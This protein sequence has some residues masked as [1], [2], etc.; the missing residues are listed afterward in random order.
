[1]S[2]A[3]EILNNLTGDEIAVHS[4]DPKTK[5]HI[6][7]NADRTIS[8]PAKLR[9]VAVEHDRDIETYTFDCPRYLDGNDLFDMHIFINYM[10]PDG[11]PGSYIAQNVVVDAA[12][13]TIIHFEWTIS[14]HVAA[15]K[16][17]LRFLVCA[18][19]VDADG[20]EDKH[21][22]S[23]LCKK[24]SISEGLEC[25]E[26]I[27]NEYPDIITQLLT[28]MDEY[29]TTGGGAAE[30]PKVTIKDDG[31]VLM[32]SDGKWAA[33]ELPRYDG[34]YSIIPSAEND[35]TLETAQKML[36]ADIKVSK[37]PYYEVSNNSGG[38][39]AYIGNEV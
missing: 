34:E 9:K 11:V 18:K 23:E 28:R 33:K 36:D 20:N 6:V 25:E 37:I 14:A 17:P 10:R 21:W 24:M 38:N 8:V 26:A 30:L 3:N 35:V 13:D 1:M 2:Q 15:V 5:P 27:V 16:G 7:I 31:K 39:T 29:E 32:V 19:S 12:D 22:N 4:G